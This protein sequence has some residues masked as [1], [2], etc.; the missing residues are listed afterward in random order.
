PHRGDDHGPPA[1]RPARLR[2]A[3][4]RARRTVRSGRRDWGRPVGAARARG[5]DVASR[6]RAAR[7][8]R[9]A[10]ASAVAVARPSGRRAGPAHGRGDQP[11]HGLD[12]GR[13]GSAGPPPEPR[14][15]PPERHRPSPIEW[16]GG[17]TLDPGDLDRVVRAALEEDL[18]YG[19]D[20]TT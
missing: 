13:R 20:V 14:L 2:A 6:R 11:A 1:R 18:R 7:R 10:W 3:A 8:D 15:P 19:P 16:S 12:A 4:P 17:M 5:G 9:A